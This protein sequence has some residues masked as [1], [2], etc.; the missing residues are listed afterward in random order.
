[1]TPPDPAGL[2]MSHCAALLDYLQWLQNTVLHNNEWHWN[3]IGAKATLTGWLVVV[4]VGVSDKDQTVCVFRLGR[5]GQTA[6]QG[7]ACWDTN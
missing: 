1:M 4:V 7:N 5:G 6:K 3:N 2:E